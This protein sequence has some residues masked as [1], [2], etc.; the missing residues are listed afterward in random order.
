[1]L[2]RFASLGSGS[3]GNGTL[4]AFGDTTLLIDCGFTLKE[5][6]A[7]LSR[8][9]VDPSAL[10]AILVTH[11][12]ADHASG[13]VALAHRFNTPVYLSYGT[14]RAMPNLEPALAR[15]FNSDEVIT[16]DDV[17]VRAVAVPH[18]AREPTQFVCGWRDTQKIGVITDVG[19]ITRHVTDSFKGC[20]GLFM[21]S[22]HDVD[23]LMRGDY[24][25]RL[26][27]RIASDQGHLS[28]EQ[29]SRFLRALLHEGLTHVVVG[30]I[31]EQNNSRAHLM[32]AFAPFEDRI[33]H[34][35]FATQDT[36]SEWVSLD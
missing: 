28:N 18:D 30:H 23:M 27:R 34:L 2:V 35:Q 17:K 6:W 32:R 4:V 16:I 22:N 29:A 26:K 13:V 7:R 20:T 5:A 10:T 25:A 3:R 15:P 31:S 8:C 33:G 12:H 21:E 11:E 24:P 19:H 14:L 9:G 1:M 36:G